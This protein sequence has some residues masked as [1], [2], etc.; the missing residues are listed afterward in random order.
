MGICVN[1]CLGGRKMDYQTENLSLED[2]AKKNIIEFPFGYSYDEYMASMNGLGNLKDYMNH[3]VVCIA[4][5]MAHYDPI[6]E[7]YVGLEPDDVTEQVRS[8]FK[9]SFHGVIGLEPDEDYFSLQRTENVFKLTNGYLQNANKVAMTL[10]I[11]KSE[12]SE[13]ADIFK[14]LQASKGKGKK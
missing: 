8:D 11:S 4:E 12:I 7:E 6:R 5:L 14:K 1:I 2:K 13:L 9:D 10:D 3:K